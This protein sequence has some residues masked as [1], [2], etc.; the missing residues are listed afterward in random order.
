MDGS[1]DIERGRKCPLSQCC[2]LAEIVVSS[3]SILACS[4]PISLRFGE[5]NFEFGT[6]EKPALY[7]RFSTPTSAIMEL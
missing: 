2:V 6:S 3:P 5:G 7:F 1:V 4:L